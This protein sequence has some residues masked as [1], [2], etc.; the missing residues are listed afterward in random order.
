MCENFW[1]LQFAS[2]QPEPDANSS[3]KEK[4][5]GSKLASLELS[6]FG[7]VPVNLKTSWRPGS[8]QQMQCWV[9]NMVDFPHFFAGWVAMNADHGTAQS[10]LPRAILHRL[11]NKVQVGWEPIYRIYL[12]VS[13]FGCLGHDVQCR[14]RSWLSVAQLK[15]ATWHLHQNNTADGKTLRSEWFWE[16]PSARSL[17]GVQ[18]TRPSYATCTSSV[19]VCLVRFFISHVDFS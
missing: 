19:V 9:G 3:F 17:W 14:Q 2:P 8:L 6:W 18:G 13:I 16:R 7:N 5:T 10:F 1:P 15:A 4:L 11:A 12:S